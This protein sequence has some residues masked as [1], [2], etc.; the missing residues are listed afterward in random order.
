[1]LV[2]LEGRF[3]RRLPLDKNVFTG[4]GAPGLCGI[5][6]LASSLKP[7]LFSCRN[8][9]CPGL[10]TEM[11]C[12]WQTFDEGIGLT[13][14]YFIPFSTKSGVDDASSLSFLLFQNMALEPFD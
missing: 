11:G 13:L 14:L 5:S 12:G 7:A 4:M 10:E 8:K 2:G 1:M 9:A 3:L 6:F